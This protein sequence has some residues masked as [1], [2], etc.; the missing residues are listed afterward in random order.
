MDKLVSEK[1]LS[2]SEAQ[3]RLARYGPNKL[4][5][6][7]SYSLAKLFFSQL[8]SPL[9]YVLLFASGVT[10]LLKDYSDALVILLAV[11]MNTALGFYQEYKAAR[12]LVALSAM[13][14]PK[15]TVLRD[16]QRQEIAADQLVPGDLVFLEIG[17]RIPADGVLVKAKDLAVNEAILNGESQAV[18]KSALE[19]K[20]WDGL[21]E[22]KV[23]SQ[24]WPKTV[25]VFMG[26]DVAA[27]IGRMVVL[28][29]GE[30][31]AVGKIAVSLASQGSEK[32]PLQKKLADFS[33]LLAII[34]AA[35][36]VFILVF[37]LVTGRSFLEIFPTSV[38]IAVSAIPEGLVVSLTAI[39][40]LGMQ[41]IL[42]RKALVRKLVAA[43]TLGG[44]TV[45]C[46][47][48]TGTLTEGKMRVVKTEFSDQHLGVLGTVLC[49]DLRDPLEVA[50]WEWGK[51]Q[52][53][54]GRISGNGLTNLEKVQD[55]Y[56]RI[57]SKPFSPEAKLILTLNQIPKQKKKILFISGAPEVV[58]QNTSLSPKE[59]KSWLEKINH[60]GQQGFRLVGFAYKYQSQAQ[61]QLSFTQVKGSQW[62][63]VVVY[64]DPVRE[65]VS[66]A[67]KK[68]LKAGIKIKVITGDHLETAKAVLKKLEL[69]EGD[70]RPEEIMLGDELEK[71][72]DAVLEN[73]VQ[74]VILFART[75]P[76]QKLRIVQALQNKGEVVAMTGDGVNDAPALKKADVGIVVSR[77]SDVSKETADMVLLD[78][79]FVTI[80][81]AVEEGR[82]IFE[83][84][85][86]VIL[87]LLSDSF[88]EMI[89][90]FGAM[91]LGLPLPLKASQILWINL[92]DDGLPSLALTLEPKDKGLMSLPPRDPKTNLLNG[93]IKTLI[94]LISGATGLVALVAFA[95]LFGDHSE[96]LKE[97][98][99]LVF[100]ILSVT[101]LFYVFSCRSLKTNLW[102]SKPWEN[103]WLTLAV[104]VGF[105][106]QLVAIY[107]PFFQSF[108]ATTPLDWQQWS[109]ILAISVGV[110]MM[111]EGIKW[112][113]LQKRHHNE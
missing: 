30:E 8:A 64:E 62:L 38:A 47:D 111:I 50:M 60:Y 45:I 55:R 12:S 46:A 79:N 24:D 78:D 32:T 81:A 107:V 14:E 10:F 85:R 28:A 63:G 11:V 61:E 31:T 25:L 43:E 96:S 67:F 13:L 99:T 84:I 113:F 82:G 36:S 9:I 106:L 26:T 93:E 71:L 42:K 21:A 72:S 68:A 66:S 18:V 70:L 20:E 101:T 34:V 95:W 35:V 54:T 2:A 110:V 90:V 105:S 75:N 39:L 103:L 3:Q 94:G 65:G 37:G 5:Q 48:K 109:W 58:L 44:V 4:A 76:Q 80:L 16:G 59:Q 87:Y 97:A 56:A 7:K 41:R 108:L 53:E 27:G 40:A 6:Q 83:N 57:T 15:A 33:Q 23:S 19:E 29:T 89:L 74:R 51:K 77:A 100:T 22:E 49:N 52:I 102:R 69:V 112:A 73:Q 92:I 98:R 17:K 91:L 86:K 104:A 88:A 1:G